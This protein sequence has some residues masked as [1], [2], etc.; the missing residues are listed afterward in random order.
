[1][2]KFFRHECR[3][4]VIILNENHTKSRG[5]FYEQPRFGNFY[6]CQK[7]KGNI[8]TIFLVE[9]FQMGELWQVEFTQ[10]TQYA[11]FY[12][13]VSDRRTIERLQKRFDKM[14][15]TP[16]DYDLRLTTGRP[17]IRP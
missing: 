1:M 6:F 13:L 14:M 15:K 3:L 9:S 10:E 11:R 17:P 12:L 2:G 5:K 16:P 7:I 4:C 8:A